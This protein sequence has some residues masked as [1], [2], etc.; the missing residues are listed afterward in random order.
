MVSDALQAFNQGVIKTTNNTTFPFVNALVQPSLAA[1]APFD[2]G[3]DRQIANGLVTLSP[4]P[5]LSVKVGYFNEQRR[6]YRGGIGTSFGF[7]NAVETPEDTS[8]LTQ[9]VGADAEISGKWGVARAALHYNWFRNS[10]PAQS[11][12]NPFLATDSIGSSLLLGPA[13]GLLSLPP[14]NDAIV[15]SAGT[16]LKL[17]KTTRLSADLSHSTWSQ[18]QTPFIPYSTNSAITTPVVATNPAALPAQA[19]A[20]KINVTSFNASFSARPASKLRFNARYRLYDLSNDTARITFPGYVPFDGSWKATPRISVPYGNKNSRL[21]ATL[22]YDLGAFSL[23]AGYKHNGINREFRETE[24]TTENGFRLGADVRRGWFVLHGGY[25]FGSRDFSGLEI[26]RSEDASFVTPITPANIY[27]APSSTLCAGGV[28]CNLRFDQ[29]PRHLNKAFALVQLT[30]TDTLVLQPVLHIREVRLPGLGLRPSVRQVQLVH[31]RGGLHAEREVERLRLLHLGRQFGLAARA[32]ERLHHL[33][34]PS[35]RL[36][37]QRG[38]QDQL[39][40]GGRHD[41]DRPVE[42]VAQPLRPLAGCRRQQRFLRARGGR[43]RQRPGGRRRRPGH[44]ELRRHGAD[45]HQCGAEVPAP[46]MGVGP[47]WVVRALSRG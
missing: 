35:R 8:Y 37:L 24:K 26:E 25:E 40:R 11:F 13:R 7:S 44:P 1:S 31:G 33:R 21:D 19:L 16:T 43:T 45:H 3:F 15:A 30:P 6:G 9:D 4:S 27:A 17:G 5:V 14:D 18:D 47:R 28:V 10:I 23:E 20:G 22:G 38:R 39:D 29:A 2:L 34:E 46:A 42:M 12:D 32:A 41:L 36:D